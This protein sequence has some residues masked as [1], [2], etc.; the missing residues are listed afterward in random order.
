LTFAI[1]F[2]QLPRMTGEKAVTGV[3]VTGKKVVDGTTTGGGAE[4]TTVGAENTTG[5]AGAMI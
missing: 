3:G 2:V 5:G 1:E 4:S